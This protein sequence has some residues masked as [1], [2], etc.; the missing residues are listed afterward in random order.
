MTPVEILSVVKR[1]GIFLTA[2]GDHITYRAPVGSMTP[3]LLEIIRVHKLSILA[4]LNPDIE[5]R[6]CLGVQC[7]H[8]RYQDVE[9]SPWL[10]CGHIEKAVVHMMVCP[11]GGWSKDRTGFP[12]KPKNR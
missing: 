11:F 6:S 10:W 2:E 7:N 5:P 9:G 12:E 8:I 4:L 3:D 1:R